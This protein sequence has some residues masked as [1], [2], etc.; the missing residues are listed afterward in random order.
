MENFILLA[1]TNKANVQQALNNFTELIGSDGS[2]EGDKNLNVGA[3]L[4]CARAYMLLKQT[5][6]AK[7]TL[8]RVVSYPWSLE[9]ADYLQQCWLL[10]ADLYINQGK[11]EQATTVLR[12]VLQHNASATKAFEYMGFLRERE[13]KF[14]DAS[15]NYECAWRLCRQRNPAIGY[16][17]AYNYLKQHNHNRLF[18]CIEVCHAVLRQYP[19]Y[20]KIK[21]EILD[22]ARANI[23]I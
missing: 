18:D 19:N 7:T 14:V 1:S 22:K 12:T 9:D 23:R 21:K 16:K 20:P 5:Q 3:I 13:Q 11:S 10:L 8:K 4:G 6:K 2:L 15:A 17:L